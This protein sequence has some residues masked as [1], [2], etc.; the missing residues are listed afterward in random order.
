ME[1][2]KITRIILP[3]LLMAPL[4][5]FATGL[6]EIQVQSNLNQPFDA[7]I[8]VIDIGNV[9][10]D[11]VT[12]QLATEQQFI[13]V[14]LTKDP[15]LSSLQFNVIR[16]KQQQTYI[17]VVSTQPIT[18][19]VLTFL[20]QLN[21]PGGQIL[22]EYTVFLDPANYAPVSTKKVTQKVPVTSQASVSTPTVQKAATYG[23]T[24][25]QDNLWEIANQNLPDSNVST[26][27]MMIAIVKLNPHAFVKNNINGLKSGYVL[28][29]PSTAQATAVSDSE[30]QTILA[31][32]NQ[33]W[34]THTQTTVLPAQSTEVMESSG[35][36]S[37]PSAPAPLD[38]EQENVPVV[39][40]T[41]AP[42]N[43]A[44]M[45]PV[46]TIG[47]E[48]DMTTNQQGAAPTIQA[49]EN[50]VSISAEAMQASTTANQSLQ[51]EVKTLQSE[52][53][54]LQRQLAEKNNE[55]LVLEKVN[56]EQATG[57]FVQAAQPT[58]ST[59]AV[60]SNGGAVTAPEGVKWY[61][62]PLILIIMVIS[63]LIGVYA[64]WRKID[65]QTVKDF[66]QRFN[67]KVIPP[68][69]IPIVETREESPEEPKKAPPIVEQE[70]ESPVSVASLAP[71][72]SPVSSNAAMLDIV[73]EADVYIAYGRYEK[74]EA[75]IKSSL[76]TNPSQPELRLKL[77]EIYFA[78]KN[79]QL[80][81]E[82]LNLLSPLTEL[83][84]TLQNKITKLINGW[85][86][87]EIDEVLALSQPQATTPILSTS[88]GEDIET[89]KLSELDIPAVE[90]SDRLVEFDG[91]MSTL[92]STTTETVNKQPTI[93]EV[94]GNIFENLQLEQDT[95]EEHPIQQPVPQENPIP[96]FKPIETPTQ[97]VETQNTP[98]ASVQT[99]LDL[100]QAYYD[101]G[102]F[103]EALGILQTIIQSG[104]ETQKKT[105]QELIDKI[106]QPRA[107]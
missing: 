104:D 54:S 76:A 59:P 81:D 60:T 40:P 93:S 17:Q 22:R 21:W 7:T 26:A 19:P 8:P 37:I 107:E 70:A 31:Q 97:T 74:A 75:L 47:Q 46:T 82:E 2:K 73:D 29:L 71:I 9:P 53:Q 105:A 36:A 14:G 64:P 15:K 68:S 89:G 83:S 62:W 63:I 67:K 12:A 28:K 24:T 69:T 49:L 99:N 101:M 45:L 98:S 86:N 33:A 85:G 87:K 34:Q 39:P 27:Q 57:S 48:S 88:P 30:A 10:P 96:E 92:Y 78:Q 102:D 18:Q 13:S 106:N 43:V 77:L 44:P 91:D 94:T 42:N 84:S 61:F 11:A 79:K 16:D 1:F 58:P 90:H 25:S 4:S 66:F 65:L 23:P 6:G 20:L 95:T 100:A 51:Q 50:E 5:C 35:Q 38:E 72:S 56:S 103:V 80:F 41:T 52:V 3:L 55:I 32:Q